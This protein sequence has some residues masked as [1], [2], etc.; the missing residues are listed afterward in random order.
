MRYRFTI[1]VHL[2]AV[3]LVS[4]K[5]P[6]ASQLNGQSNADFVFHGIAV[7]QD[8]H[9]LPGVGF[10]FT[11]ESFPEDWTFETR[12]RPN[13]SHAITLVSDENGRFRLSGRGC[14]IFRQRAERS[15]YRHFF[16]TDHGEHVD[17]NRREFV[18][19]S[20][21]AFRIISWGN[22]CYRN[23]EQHPAV[24]VFVK[25]GV[26]ETSALPSRGGFSPGNRTVWRENEPGWPRVPSLR[27]VVKKAPSTQATSQS[28]RYP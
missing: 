9:P 12:G 5:Q 16:D 7:D 25:D 11:V 24:F 27:D 2:V 8:G 28:T 20:N 4:C 15:G 1:V 22:L 26:Q 14:T 3:L 17:R 10:E 6:S 18:S 13:L 21:Y 23:D 19:Y